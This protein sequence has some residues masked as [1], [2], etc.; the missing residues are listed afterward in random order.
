MRNA[1][2]LNTESF[3]YRAFFKLKKNYESFQVGVFFFVMNRFFFLNIKH[4]KCVHIT[5]R[6]YL[7]YKNGFIINE[8]ELNSLNKKCKVIT[9]N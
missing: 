2:I 3:H 5:Q 7:V 8:M 1:E 4:S 6:N 9:V